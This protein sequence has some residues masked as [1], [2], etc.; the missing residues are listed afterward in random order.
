MHKVPKG[1]HA[2]NSSKLNE[3]NEVTK[4]QDKTDID[5]WNRRTGGELF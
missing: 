3:S 1:D 4:T 2:D 5:Q